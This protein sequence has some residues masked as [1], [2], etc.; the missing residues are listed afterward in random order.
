V[1]S[2]RPFP[3]S[4]LFWIWLFRTCPLIDDHPEEIRFAALTRRSRAGR[5]DAG[6][7]IGRRRLLDEDFHQIA[8]LLAPG[9]RKRPDARARIRALLAVEAHVREDGIVSK[10]DVDRVEKAIRAGGD[11]SQVF[12]RLSEIGTSLAGEGVEIQV[13]FVKKGGVPVHYVGREDDVA[14]G[15]IR[16]VDLQNKY[17][18]SKTDLASKLGPD[19]GRC[20]ALRWRLGV[21]DDDD[22]RSDFVFGSQIHREY[23]DNA[24]KR[25]EEALQAG[26][27]MDE[28]HR[29]YVDS[30][31]GN[32][33]FIKKEPV[34]A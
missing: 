19:T 2:G 1:R 31:Y 7:P 5:P 12:P 26:L 22:C 24:Y 32:E 4:R 8:Q 16:Q 6:R 21:D 23:S 3:S 33:P 14:A 13:R 10:Q 28:V 15:A 11:R 27:T 9:K 20:K 34:S 29:Q 17:H 18:W 30:D 25:M